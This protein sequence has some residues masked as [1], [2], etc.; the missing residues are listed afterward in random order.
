MPDAGRQSLE[1][2][3]APHLWPLP[4]APWGRASGPQTLSSEGLTGHRGLGAAEQR[5]L[6]VLPAPVTEAG[7]LAARSALKCR[8][9][10]WG[11]EEAPAPHVCLKMLS[12]GRPV[13]AS[14]PGR[15]RHAHGQQQL[16]SSVSNG[17]VLCVVSR[18]LKACAW[19]V[20]KLGCGRPA[21]VVAVPSGL[22]DWQAGIQDVGVEFGTFLQAESSLSPQKTHRP[23]VSGDCVQTPDR[24]GMAPPPG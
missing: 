5:C 7:E 11:A 18:R 21:A 20:L 3:S 8:S 17:V 16:F 22:G 9:G 4:S 2:G 24:M 1:P 14:L 23:C 6:S 15:L 12:V 10:G 19:R 13:A